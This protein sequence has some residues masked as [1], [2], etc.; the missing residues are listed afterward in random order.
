[1]K[2]IFNIVSFIDYHFFAGGIFAIILC[3]IGVFLQKSISPSQSE[4]KQKIKLFLSYMLFYLTC[5]IMA[6]IFVSM[7]ARV[8]LIYIGFSK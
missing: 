1:M 6:I 4:H 3:L 7:I 5:A 2:F 8:F